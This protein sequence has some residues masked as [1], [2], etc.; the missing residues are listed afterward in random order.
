MA[1]STEE[2][3][4]RFYADVIVSAEWISSFCNFRVV[5]SQTRKSWFS[6]EQECIEWEVR[7]KKLTASRAEAFTSW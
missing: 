4:N 5:A 2:N 3:F 6:S 7:Q 1:I